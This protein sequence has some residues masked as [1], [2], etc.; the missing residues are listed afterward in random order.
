M[1]QHNGAGGIDP[2]FPLLTCRTKAKFRNGFS[3]L[4]GGIYIIQ[5]LFIFS[6][7]KLFI[8]LKIFERMKLLQGKKNLNSVFEYETQCIMLI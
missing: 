5:S 3:Q 1:N 4:K 2:Q 7:N 6:Q 8:L